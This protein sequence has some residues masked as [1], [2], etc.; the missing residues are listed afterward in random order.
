MN[1]GTLHIYKALKNE[2]TLHMRIM[3][4][5]A[6]AP[7]ARGSTVAGSP[8]VDMPCSDASIPT[9]K[10]VMTMPYVPFMLQEVEVEVEVEELVEVTQAAPPTQAELGEATTEEE[11]EEEGQEEGQEEE[12]QAR[13]SCALHSTK[14]VRLVHDKDALH[15]NP[16]K[17]GTFANNVLN[18]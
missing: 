14:A 2:D 13:L 6:G 12:G 9:R 7:G 18:T 8:W 15:I 17:Q 16:A 4:L 5:G 1:R 3:R 11:E 10:A